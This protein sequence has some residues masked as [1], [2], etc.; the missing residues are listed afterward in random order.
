MSTLV[1]RDVRVFDGDNLLERRDVVVEGERIVGVSPAGTAASVE[2]IIEGTGHMLLPGLFDA[3]IHLP[4]VA[5]SALRQCVALGVTTVLDMFGNPA[6]AALRQ[7]IARDED[8]R[9]SAEFQLAGLG[10]IGPGSLLGQMVEKVTGKTL[11]SVDSPEDAA[12]WVDERIAEGSDYIKVIYDE[13]EGGQMSPATLKGIVTAAHRRDRRVVVHALTEQ[14]AREAILAGTDGLAHLFLGTTASEGFGEVA[15]A[16]DVFVIP[17][18]SVLAGLTGTPQSTVLSADP[19]LDVRITD[20]QRQTPL[21]PVD[22]AQ[23][24]LYAGTVEALHQ[25]VSAGVPILAGTDT[26]EATAG[27]G[28]SAYGATVHGEL[29]LLVDAGMSPEQALIAATSAPADAFGLTHL[30]RIAKGKQADLVLVS[31]DPT[32]EITDTRNV[33]AV[34][35]RG[36][37]V[38]LLP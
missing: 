19:R 10:A 38:R 20:R 25:L 28:V 9:G 11:P 1:I 24:R 5:E 36:S 35:K 7:R 13:R 2:E 31:G 30:G 18:L 3:H 14:R 22:P 21:I 29:K 16:H 37:R 17:T 8:W 27:F 32:T 23:G 15:A 34:W 33:T 12:S 6:M 4:D 26:G